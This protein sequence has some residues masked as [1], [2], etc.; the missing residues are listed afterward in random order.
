MTSI[1]KLLIFRDPFIKNLRKVWDNYD[2]DHSGIMEK[3]EFIQFI[4]ELNVSIPGLTPED[5]FVKIDLDKSGKID[6]Q[7]FVKYYRELTSGKEFALIF[8]SYSESK[9]FLTLKEFK[10]FM[11]EVQKARD[12]GM[13]DAVCLFNEFCEGIPKNIKQII[14]KKMDD[15]DLLS[16]AEEE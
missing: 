3:A 1:V 12:F 14:N 15:K 2:Q 6:F 9:D 5:L 4:K 10:R 16:R 13:L 11:Q 7:E 8:E